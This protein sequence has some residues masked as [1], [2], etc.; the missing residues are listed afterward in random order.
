MQQ[1][2]PFNLSTRELSNDVGVQII[3]VGLL[4]LGEAHIISL[5]M[6]PSFVNF[7]SSVNHSSTKMP[8]N[9]NI[10]KAEESQKQHLH[11]SH[12]FLFTVIKGTFLS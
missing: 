2:V 6:Y 11:Y 10:S 12:D 1:W 4:L 3:R 9:T 7:F 8:L 5:V